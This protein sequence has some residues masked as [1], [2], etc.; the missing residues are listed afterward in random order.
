MLKNQALM[1]RSLCLNASS[2]HLEEKR[3]MLSCYAKRIYERNNV[4]TFSIFKKLTTFCIVTTLLSMTKFSYSATIE[5]Y[6]NARC[7]TAMGAGPCQI[8]RYDHRQDFFVLHYLD[9]KH[10]SVDRGVSVNV[11]CSN[12]MSRRLDHWPAAHARFVK[13][14]KS[15]TLEP[16]SVVN[17]IEN[18][19]VD[20]CY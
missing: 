2:N 11:R 18:Y 19:S 15:I 14:G 13:F 17:N 10:I 16:C 20:G 8:V 9:A 7:D 4:R 5:L 6:K 3:Q 12:G 1:M